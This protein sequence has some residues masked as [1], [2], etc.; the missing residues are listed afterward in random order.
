VSLPAF[1][2]AIVVPDAV[3]AGASIDDTRLRTLH[4]LAR[5]ADRDDIADEHTARVGRTAALLAERLGLPAADV[6]LL[7]HAAPLHD[8]GKLAV[9]DAILLKPGALTVDEVHQ[10][11]QHVVSG[12][13]ML[14]GGASDVIRLAREIV[15]THHEWWDGS[16]YPCGLAGAAI[17]LCGRI[18]A[19]A[20]VFDALTHERPYKRAWPV[21]Q[22]VAEVRRLRSKQF[23]PA[24][25]DAFETIDAREII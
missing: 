10:M 6:A 9:S 24:V 14:S 11:R 19:L 16:G 25:V 2:P 13:A 20:D 15:L 18:V 4:R 8:I 1:H 17:P 23:D 7:R 3:R 22:A 21:E 12:A 5:S